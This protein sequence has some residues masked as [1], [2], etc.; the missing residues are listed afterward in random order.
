MQTDIVFS[1]Y[2]LVS[3]FILECGID[4]DHSLHPLL[5]LE[6]DWDQTAE[7]TPLHTQHVLWRLPVVAVK[8]LRR[9]PTQRPTI[10]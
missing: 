5:W 3:I 4:V 2:V 1:T 8:D 7:Q 9:N 10:L 6:V